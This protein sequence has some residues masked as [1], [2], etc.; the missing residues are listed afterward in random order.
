MGVHCLRRNRSPSTQ[1]AGVKLTSTCFTKVMKVML[2]HRETSQCEVHPSVRCTSNLHHT[3]FQAPHARVNTESENVLAS[4]ALHN[5]MR[6]C[7]RAPQWRSRA[8]GPEPRELSRVVSLSHTPLG[9]VC[10]SNVST[11]VRLDFC[12][13]S[14]STTSHRRH[15]AQEPRGA[16]CNAPTTSRLNDSIDY[17]Y[18]CRASQKFE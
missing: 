12:W 6:S 3:L 13:R 1:C 16:E 14:P 8:A 11:S 9:T 5:H 15:P 4:S 10:G 17:R 18:E 7:R 2:F